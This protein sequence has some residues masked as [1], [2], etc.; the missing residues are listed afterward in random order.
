LAQKS[1]SVALDPWRHAVAGFL[2]G[3][4]IY[5]IITAALQCGGGVENFFAGR[6]S[7]NKSSKTAITS[8]HRFIRITAATSGVPPSSRTA[9]I[10]LYGTYIHGTATEPH[11][12]REVHD[13]PLNHP[14]FIP[15]CGK[16]S[17]GTFGC[18][19][20]PFHNLFNP[21]AF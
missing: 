8:V 10:T 2:P 18:K 12:P 11:T 1:T 13:A 19:S 17:W 4:L 6:V 14:P 16:F 3:D 5:V 9:Y 20:P 15:S 7:P 21:C